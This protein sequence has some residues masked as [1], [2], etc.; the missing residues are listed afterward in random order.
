MFASG[1]IKP[2]EAAI[3]A[4]ARKLLSVVSAMLANGVD[5][6]AAPEI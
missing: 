3:T 1:E 2:V 5:D 6:R 4:A